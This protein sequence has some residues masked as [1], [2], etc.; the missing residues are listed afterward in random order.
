MAGGAKLPIKGRGCIQASNNK[1]ILK[2]FYVPDIKSNLM[3]VGSLTGRGHIVIFTTAYCFITD[4][5]NHRNVYL[6]GDRHPSHRLYTLQLPE[7]RP[8]K[9]LL[10]KPPDAKGPTAISAPTFAPIACTVFD[11][12]DRSNATE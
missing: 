4:P 3:S 1:K 9:I 5:R 7:S 11:R 12:P 10:G 6:K 8:N 2:V